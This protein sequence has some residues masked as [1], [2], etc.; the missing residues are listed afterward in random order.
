MPDVL[1]DAVGDAIDPVQ[2]AR[3][4]ACSGGEAEEADHPVNVDE[5]DGSM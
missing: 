3:E 5:E 2:G 1:R 4:I